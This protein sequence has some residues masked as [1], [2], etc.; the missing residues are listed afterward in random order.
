MSLYSFAWSLT[1]LTNYSY[2]E[3]VWILLTKYIILLNNI[4]ILVLSL[5]RDKQNLDGILV[6][7]RNNT[8]A[9]YITQQNSTINCGE[10]LLVNSVV[11]HFENSSLSLL[12]Q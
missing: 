4:S 3:K 9:M 11:T 12:V 10:Y 8:P 7:G 5:V 1:S 6:W 2:V